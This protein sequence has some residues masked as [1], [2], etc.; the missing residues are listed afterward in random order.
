M[1]KTKV[2]FFVL[3][4]LYGLNLQAVEYKKVGVTKV[5]KKVNEC[6]EAIFYA[7]SKNYCQE[8]KVENIDMQEILSWQEEPLYRQAV[9]LVTNTNK[10]ITK[11]ITLGDPEDKSTLKK[12]K[13]AVPD[14][15]KALE[16]FYKSAKAKNNPLS[17][18]TG[19]NIINSYIPIVDKK[20]VEMKT[21][22]I[23]VLYANSSCKGFLE[24]GDREF[25]IERKDKNFL[26][27]HSL[28]IYTTG[29]KLCDTVSYYGTLLESRIA[30]IELMQKNN[31]KDSK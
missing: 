24:K 23:K 3:G 29:L 7:D 18:F 9:Y 26:F 15:I 22:F 25:F 8:M 2:L 30:R 6:K 31:K 4:L 17:A 14:Y 19:L 5:D 16:L 27:P 13:I 11:E 10:F 20:T 1:K 21:Y 12:G 28:K